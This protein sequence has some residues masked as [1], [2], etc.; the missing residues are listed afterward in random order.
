MSKSLSLNKDQAAALYRMATGSD[1]APSPESVE[2]GAVPHDH[3]DVVNKLRQMAAE[4]LAP[5][6]AEEKKESG[7]PKFTRRTA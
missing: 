5:A 2:A 3:Q 1:H 4:A 7:P 6:P